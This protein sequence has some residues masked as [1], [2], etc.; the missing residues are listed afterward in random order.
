LGH[1]TIQVSTL[2]A[3]SYNQIVLKS[4]HRS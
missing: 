3:R 4:D 2:G 1:T